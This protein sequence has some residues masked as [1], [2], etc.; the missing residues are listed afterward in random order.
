MSLVVTPTP[1]HCP[2]CFAVE[3]LKLLYILNM[4]VS[5]HFIVLFTRPGRLYYVMVYSKRV[6][7]VIVASIM[8]QYCTGPE[9]RFKFV[10]VNISWNWGVVV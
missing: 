3:F 8:W 9:Y 6:I 7:W 10:I 2:C 5:G 4:P 1:F